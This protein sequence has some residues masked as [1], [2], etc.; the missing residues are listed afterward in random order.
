MNLLQEIP[1]AVLI[2]GAVMLGLYISNLIY[3]SGALQHHVSRKLGHLGGCVAFLLAPFLFSSFVWPFILTT[4]F[5]ALLLYARW[6]RPHSFRGTGG[7]G[8]PQALAEVH[9][10]AVGIVLIGVLWGMFDQPWLAIVPLLYMAGGDSITGLVRNRLYSV[11]RKDNWG[12]LA[13]LGVCLL[14]AYFIQPYWIGLTGA[15]VA[16]LAERFSPTN[17]VV[18]DN[19]LIPLFSGVS[20]ALLYFV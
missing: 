2:A 15:I 16:V 20:M 4:G 18:D 9:F 12:S 8:R 19:L 10:P 17:R 13:M 3:D 11:E 14:F 1:Y 6:K 7:S 5:T